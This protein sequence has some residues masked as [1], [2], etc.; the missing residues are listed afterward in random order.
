MDNEQAVAAPEQTVI[1]RMVA[2]SGNLNPGDI[3]GFPESRAAKL[4][5][6]KVAIPQVVGLDVDA[7]GNPLRDPVEPATATDD[8]SQSSAAKSEFKFDPKT[9]PFTT[10]GISK[11]ASQALH[12][13]GIHTVEAVRNFIASLPEGADPVAEINQMEG[14]SDAQAEKIVKLYGMTTEH[15][16]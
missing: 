2:K 5:A 9:D 1:V 3:A 6:D 14:I 15:S 16:E 10:D 13:Q 7:D 8:S 12:A 11:Q 4:I